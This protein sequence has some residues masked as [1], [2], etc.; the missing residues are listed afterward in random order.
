MNIVR[1][2]DTIS[3]AA[4]V[5]ASQTAGQPGSC[6]AVGLILNTTEETMIERMTLRLI[7]ID[8]VRDDRFGSDE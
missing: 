4:Y 3:P 7:M 8:V 1:S 6:A 2:S 5:P